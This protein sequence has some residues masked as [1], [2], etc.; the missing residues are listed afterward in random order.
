MREFRTDIAWAAGLF[1][2]EGTI[3]SYSSG[4]NGAGQSITAH[5]RLGM[6]D[7]DVVERFAQVVGFG[8][9]HVRPP[10]TNG[11][12]A[13]FAWQAYGFEK[14]QALTAM[15]WPW[16]G[17]RRRAK[18]RETIIATRATQAMGKRPCC[19]QGHPY[20]ET[21]WLE[22][23]VRNGRVYFA[24]RCRTCR[25]AQERAR[26]RERLGITPERYRRED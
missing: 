15:F 16:L 13:I 11:H 19:P 7:R 10:G 23:I 12:K 22:R 26:K 5:L 6:T 17:E 9:I 20:S 1:E 25:Q 8:A 3:G 21:L 18:A 24:R 4:R 14:A 2:G